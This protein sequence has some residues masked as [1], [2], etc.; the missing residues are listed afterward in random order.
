M[1][2]HSAIIS[3]WPAACA[4]RE[5]EGVGGSLFSTVTFGPGLTP[6]LFWRTRRPAGLPHMP[7]PLLPPPQALQPRLGN[8]PRFYQ[9]L[10]Q[11]APL[12]GCEFPHGFRDWPLL[13][14]RGFRHV[15]CLAASRP[16]YSPAPL[17][18][19]HACELDDLSVIQMP[20]DPAAEAKHIRGIARKVAV[21]IQSGEGV[22]VHCA[23]G[24]GR[25]GTVLGVTL[26]LLGMPAREVIDYLD[27]LH[28]QRSGKGWPESLWQSRLVEMTRPQTIIPCSRKEK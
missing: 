3:N 27:K 15:I 20:D 2:A 7:L 14:E 18:I 1:S 16:G 5:G 17:S 4:G 10:E 19:L 13:H 26:R 8:P 22:L 25:T 28:C 24:R 11:P 9:L 6:V 12:A 23:A 21:A